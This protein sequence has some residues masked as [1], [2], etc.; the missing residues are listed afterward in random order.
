MLGMTVKDPVTGLQGITT[1]RLELLSGSIQYTIQP[2][3]KPDGEVP[4]G[5]SVDFNLLQVIDPGVSGG[6]TA[7]DPTVDIKLGDLVTD[8]VTGV[9]G[10]A[11]EKSVFLNGCV[12]FSVRGKDINA[13]LKSSVFCHHA[14]LRHVTLTQDDNAEDQEVE[15]PDTSTPEELAA[16]VTSPPTGGPSRR[17]VR[18]H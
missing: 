2:P 15:Q 8:L 6:V 16:A 3:V 13:L 4:D 10:L 17:G 12:Y 18:E 11:I 5:H 14:R 7:E 9:T 1:A